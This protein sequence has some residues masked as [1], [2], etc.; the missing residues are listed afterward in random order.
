MRGSEFSWLGQ[1][2]VATWGETDA[3]DARGGRF[4]L[5]TVLDSNVFRELGL[6]A[7]QRVD[8]RRNV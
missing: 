4:P 3:W 8:T 6:C 7:M 5:G 2:A 1:N